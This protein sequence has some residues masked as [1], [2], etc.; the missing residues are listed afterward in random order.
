MNQLLEDV[1][2][3]SNVEKVEIEMEAV[4]LNVLLNKVLQTLHANIEEQEAKIIPEDL[5]VIHGNE[6]QIFQVFQNLI[7]NAMKF[8]PNDCQPK[9]HIR[10]EKRGDHYCIS[11]QDNGIGIEE[12]Y[13]ENIFSL[14]KRLHNSQEYSGTG[15][16]LSICKKIIE[17]HKGEIW[18][19]SDGVSGSTFYFTLPPEK[20]IIKEDS[21]TSLEKTAIL[22][23]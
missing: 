19:E 10:S 7:S 21:N 13:Q 22:E 16:G 11:I 17:R 23:N 4:D 6:M 2:S 9:I 5:P 8:V 3:Y 12:K 20:N 18:I 14:F 15:L 1:L